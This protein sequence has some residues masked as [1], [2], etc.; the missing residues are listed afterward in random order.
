MSLLIL[1]H[2]VHSVLSVIG[3][4][5]VPQTPAMPQTPAAVPQT[6]AA[7]RQ[8]P[9][10]LRVGVKYFQTYLSTITSTETLV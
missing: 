3:S 7:V 6:P 1:S 8:T 2:M 5:T 10:A 4:I 9:A